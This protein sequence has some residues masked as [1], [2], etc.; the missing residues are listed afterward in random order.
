[1]D[2]PLAMLPQERV[3][4]GRETLQKNMDELR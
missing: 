1:V 2:E 4:P 3:R